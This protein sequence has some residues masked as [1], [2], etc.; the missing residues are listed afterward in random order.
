[1]IKGKYGKKKRQ[2]RKENDVVFIWGEWIKGSMGG[3]TK[4]EK[5]K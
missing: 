5:R 1:M 4:K 2:R 3:R